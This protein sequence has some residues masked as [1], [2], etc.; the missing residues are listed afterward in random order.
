MKFIWI[1]K[2]I[3]GASNVYNPSMREREIEKYREVIAFRLKVVDFFTRHGL[4]LTVEAFGVSKSKIYRWRRRLKDAGGAISALAPRSRAPRRKRK[5]QIHPQIIEFI[6]RIRRAHPRMGKE[7]IKVLLDDYCKREGLLPVS[8]S[9]IGRII[10][11]RGLFFSPQE[12]THS[13]KVKS[14]SRVKKLR[15]RNYMPRRSGDLIQLDSLHVFV[16][17]IKRYIITA[18]DLRS[19]F[20]F[21]YAYKSLSSRAGADFMEKFMSVAPFSITHI[22]TDNG[23]EF[24]KHFHRLVEREKVVHFFNYPRRPQSNGHI[25]RFNRTLQEEFLLYHLDELATNIGAF[26]RRLMQWL[27]FYNTRRPHHSL[28]LRSPLK[29]LIEEENFSHMLWTYTI[30]GN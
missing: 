19:R 28:S 2:W 3:R 14:K 1:Y 15:R 16:D 9:T 11:E 12:F 8:A 20:A 6:E 4:A 7:K 25:E 18:V 29:Y 23:S 13:G 22:Q 21:A 10:K 24:M 17:G 26:N 27:V 5:R 30:I